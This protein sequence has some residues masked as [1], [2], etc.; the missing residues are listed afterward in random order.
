MLARA[1][2]PAE[3]V[4]PPETFAY[5]TPAKAEPLR[6]VLEVGAVLTVGFVWYATSAP[7]VNRWDVGYRWST[8]REKITFDKVGFDANSLGT[9]FIGH[10]LGGTGYYLAARSNRLSILESFGV[11]VA[12]S[13]IWEL[14]GEVSEVVSVNDMV[15]TPLAGIAIG[16]ATTQLA[17]YF[18]RSPRSATHRTFGAVFGPFKTL[19]DRFDSL[20]PARRPAYPADEWHRFD[21][22]VALPLTREDPLQSTHGPWWP[23]G[24]IELATHLVR[25]PGYDAS[26]WDSRWFGD[27]NASRLRFTAS[28]GAAGVTDL[29]FTSH[30]VLAGGYYRARR[31]DFEGNAW[32]SNGLAGVTAGFQYTVHRYR[33]REG[34]PIDR[35]ASVRPLGFAFEQRG[36]IGGP[37]LSTVLELGP[38]FAG[39]TP[40]GIRDYGRSAG[41]PIVQAA[42][43]YYFGVGGHLRAAAELEQEQLVASGE[44]SAEAFRDVRG[45]E[46]PAGPALTDVL[47]QYRVALGYRQTTSVLIPKVFLERRLRIGGVG[48]ARGTSDE[49][50]LGVGVGARF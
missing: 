25:L 16:E 10:P 44:L 21:V 31:R 34:G 43:G 36:A 42:R 28:A 32:G 11:S 19:N 20:E 30:V 47:A 1:D 26:G 38:D 33:R 17:A 2:P 27:A 29:A 3:M 9:N 24:R 48:R 40:Q 22:G 15:V 46:D 41:L 12:G 50:S 13:Y 49:L 23:E 37:T 39:V 8:F 14:L 5:T 4:S 35:I 7:N 18:D 45:P 6:A